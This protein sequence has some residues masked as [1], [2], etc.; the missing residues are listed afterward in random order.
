LRPRGF[1]APTN[2]SMGRCSP[3]QRA[4]ATLAGRR[5]TIAISRC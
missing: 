3:S 1:E 2:C 4:I 5:E